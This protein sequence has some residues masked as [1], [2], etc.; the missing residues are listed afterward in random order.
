VHVAVSYDPPSSTAAPRFNVAAR[1][2][3]VAL[4]TA[5]GA[6]LRLVARRTGLLKEVACSALRLELRS[7]EGSS[8]IVEPHHHLEESRDRRRRRQATLYLTEHLDPEDF[9]PLARHL[10]RYFEVDGLA[11]ALTSFLLIGES[12]LASEGLGSN[13]LIDARQA[14][15]K[16]PRLPEP[17]D[18][19]TA[20][21][22][23]EDGEPVT[24]EEG[25]D[26]ASEPSE[27]AGDVSEAADEE[28][29]DLGWSDEWPSE[30]PTKHRDPASTGGGLGSA[31]SGGPAFRGLVSDAA[32]PEQ[33]D[34][35]SVTFGEPRS[36]GVRQPKAPR[37]SP[38]RDIGEH[39]PPAPRVSARERD[40]TDQNAMAIVSRFAEVE[41]GAKVNRVD[42]LNLGWDLELELDGATL[43][44]EVKGFAAGSSSFIITR[45]ELRA[46]GSEA[47]YRVAVVSG[48]GGRSGSIAFITDFAGSLDP[49][50]LKPMSWA[51]EEWTRLPHEVR[52]WKVE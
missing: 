6:D 20:V 27:V 5:R 1:E 13:E 35:D 19:L 8:I 21:V 11:D 29:D 34:L 23:D 51:V 41:L 24:G 36:G 39:A 25:A 7:S 14:L 47:N 16:Y 45:N 9:Q 42:D 40:A 43:L 30:K 12:F 32:E 22:K 28:D 48:V 17:E 33:I 38:Q 4:L 31:R 10:A 37:Q 2:Q 15:A 44:V 3:L 46:A 18:L 50:Q 26:V 49:E 52:P